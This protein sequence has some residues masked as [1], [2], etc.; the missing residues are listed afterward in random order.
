MW[1]LEFVVLSTPKSQQ[2][3][4]IGLRQ[5]RQTVRTAASQNWN[6][7]QPVV[8]TVA[9]SITFLFDRFAGSG[10]E[11]DVDNVAKPIIDALKGL[12][13]LDDHV[14]TDLLCRKRY[15]NGNLQIR[16]IS[17]ILRQTLSQSV[18]FVH[19]VVNDAPIQA[20]SL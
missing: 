20:V 7:S 13:Y 16:N 6:A 11:P 2:G 19:V 14:V 5:W 4:A 18:E 17:P 15:L 12:V 10:Q 1:P 3:S 9:V 8:G